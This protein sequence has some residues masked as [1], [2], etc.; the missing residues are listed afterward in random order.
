MLLR[1]GPSGVNFASMPTVMIPGLKCNQCG[2]E[3]VPRDINQPPAVCPNVECKSFRWDR[4]KKVVRRRRKKGDAP[5]ELSINEV[6]SIA[7]TVASSN[8]A[9]PTVRS[10]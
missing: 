3:W 6:D 9:T 2:H 8:G 4:T 7:A 10:A 5:R 1:Y